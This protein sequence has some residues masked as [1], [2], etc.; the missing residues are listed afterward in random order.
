MRPFIISLLSSL[1]I[2]MHEGKGH[3]GQNNYTLRKLVVIENDDWWTWR[4]VTCDYSS[5]KGEVEC[6]GAFP[7]QTIHWRKLGI[8]FIGEYW[9]R[10]HQNLT[11][12]LVSS[13]L[14]AHYCHGPKRLLEDPSN[15]LGLFAMLIFF[16]PVYWYAFFRSSKLLRSLA[17]CSATSWWTL[18]KHHSHTSTW[19]GLLA[20]NQLKI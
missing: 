7:C 2:E 18:I 20:N 11:V 14:L 4:V 6:F 5:E 13:A 15:T 17:E 16:V 9:L 8:N 10:K 1:L 12:R 3:F 19:T